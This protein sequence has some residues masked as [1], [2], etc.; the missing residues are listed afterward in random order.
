LGPSASAVI[1]A[2]GQSS[3][4]S[5]FGLAEALQTP[6]TEV[7]LFGKPSI[8]GHRRLGVALAQAEDIA[9]ARLQASAA[10]AS[11]TVVFEDETSP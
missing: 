3:A 5:F 8:D 1:L 10:A 11:V 6:N 9:G 2:E 7:R 4:I